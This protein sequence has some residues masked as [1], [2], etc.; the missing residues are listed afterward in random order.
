MPAPVTSGPAVPW[1]PLVVC[2]HAEIGRRVTAALREVVPNPPTVVAE[3]PRMGTLAALA[4]QK[5][6]NI[7]FLDVATNAEHAQVLIAELAP[8]MPVVALMVRNDADLIL[9]CLRRGAC[10]FLAEPGTDALRGVF[11]RLGRVRT[12]GPHH[13]SGTIWCVV[14]GKPGSG[15]STLAVHLAIQSAAA[16]GPVL[17][18]DTDA[19]A[20]SAAFLLKLKPEFHLG[21]VLRDWKRMDEDLWGRLTL[22]ACGVDVLAAPEDA[23]TPHRPGTAGGR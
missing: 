22:P 18:V 8:A 12:P 10:E 5:G 7:C 2:P 13:P 23:A 19:L 4:A 17:L 9:R 14:P 6:A 20:A 21:D 1:N 3:Y 15:A 11:E 16:G